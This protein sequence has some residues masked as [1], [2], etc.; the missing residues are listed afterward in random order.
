MSRDMM[1][2]VAATKEHH[3]AVAAGEKGE[4]DQIELPVGDDPIVEPAVEAAAEPAAEGVAT[5]PAATEPEE[6]IIVGDRTFTSQKEALAYAKE[7]AQEKEILEAR[8]AGMQEVLEATRSGQPAA[9]PAAPEEDKFEEEFYSNPKETLQKVASKAKQ[10][11]V[12][13]I[14]AEINREKAW[15]VFLEK[16]PDIER[17]DA[18]RIMRENWVKLEKIK[19]E[20]KGMESLATL[21]R[22]YYDGIIER[23]KPRTALPDNKRQAVS[24]AGGAPARVTPSNQ[25][26]KPLSMAEQMRQLKR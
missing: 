1:K 23:R 14:R 3:A 19:D 9:A 24:P 12:A 2:E 5:E 4:D 20:A 22:S 6:E 16:Y 7:L 8:Q 15:D 26:Q 25:T 10:D 17:A 13:E 21:V 11:A 18:E